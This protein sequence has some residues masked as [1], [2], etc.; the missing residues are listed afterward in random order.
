MKKY[1]SLFCWQANLQVKKCPLFTYN[2]VKPEYRFELLILVWE[3]HEKGPG[4]WGTFQVC[5]IC[6]RNVLSEMYSNWLTRCSSLHVLS[7]G[8]QKASVNWARKNRKSDKHTWNGKIIAGSWASSIGSGTLSSSDA[9]KY[10]CIQW[11][12]RNNRIV[13]HEGGKQ[14]WIL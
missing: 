11:H 9:D 14:A 13:E 1:L 4:I 2:F 8:M 10:N 3:E 5:N 7:I 12:M 6:I